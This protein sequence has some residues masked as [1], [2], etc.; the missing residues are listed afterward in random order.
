MVFHFSPGPSQLFH[1]V[2]QHIRQALNDDFLCKSHRGSEFT[3]VY[4]SCV[5]NLRSLFNLDD[6][7]EVLFTSS[8][9]E[10][11]ERMLQNLVFER[12][13]FLVTGSFSERARRIGDDLDLKTV[14]RRIKETESLPN[15][16]EFEGAELLNLAS[17]ETS[18]G[19][20][21]GNDQIKRIKAFNPNALLAVDVVSAAPSYQIPLDSID[22]FYFSVQKGFGL[23]SGLGVWFL[24]ENAIRKAELVNQS[25]KGIPFYRSVPGMIQKTRINQTLATPN[26][27][28][29]F[30]LNLVTGDFLEMG[31][32]LIRRDTEYKKALLYHNLEELDGFE[33]FIEPNQQKSTTTLV[34]KHPNA[35]YVLS[36]LKKKGYVLGSGYGPFKKEHIRIAN[37][38]S[39][40]REL[41]ETLVDTIKSI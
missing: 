20:Q 35:S 41:M 30:L 4:A 26:M 21:I 2:P 34:F 25:K 1:T 22:T 32:D 5:K 15:E 17:N 3:S 27:L 23:P 16:L 38:P 10:V 36:E 37:F 31:L 11:W 29:I 40:S 39:H 28:D 24:N 8:A 33:S 13:G 7:W 14:E 6:S 9:T 12:A 18:T 19:Y